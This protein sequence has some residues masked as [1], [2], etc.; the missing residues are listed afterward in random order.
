MSKNLNYQCTEKLTANLGVP[1]ITNLES[2]SWA[3]IQE[4]ILQLQISMAY[5]LK[6]S[7]D[8]NI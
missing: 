5:L 1:K 2:W 7:Q 3:A 6:S 4:N 8:C